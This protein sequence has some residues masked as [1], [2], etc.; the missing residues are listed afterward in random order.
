ML[1][2]GCGSGFGNNL[3]VGLSKIGFTVFACCLND[4]SE[5][6]KKLKALNAEK[7]GSKIHVIRMD[8]TNQEQVDDAFNYVKNNLKKDEA[9]WG[10]VNNAGVL[11]F[12]FVEWF[13]ME[14][15][16]KV[17]YILFDHQ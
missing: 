17:N 6:A 9:L 11:K 14:D 16:E 5:G 1:I 8:V 12:G 3:A 15:F 10:L 4:Q 7:S 13:S 2:T